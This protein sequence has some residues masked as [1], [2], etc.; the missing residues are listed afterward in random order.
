MN[1]VLYPQLGTQS[2][3]CMKRR[4]KTGGHPYTY[5][6]KGNLLERLARD[7]NMSI[8]EA[9]NKLLQE[10]KEILEQGGMG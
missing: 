5:N 10:R 8:E 9:R 1:L 6:P 2:R 3:R 4:K 7:N